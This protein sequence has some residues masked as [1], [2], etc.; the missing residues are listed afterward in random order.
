MLAM[1]DLSVVILALPQL[2]ADLNA[3]SVQAL[4][5]T[6]IYGFLIAGF[7]VTM[8]RLGDR[9]GHRNLLLIGAAAFGLLSIAAAYSTSAEMLIVIRALLGVAGGTI[10]PCVL[11]LLRHMFQ[12]PKQMGTAMGIWSAA[13]MAGVSLGPALGG[14]LLNS[15]WWGSIFLIATPIMLLLMATG[16]FLLPG[17]R[18]AADSGP[19]DLFSVVLSLAA[20]LPVI[21]GLKELARAG[22]SAQAIAAIAAGV[23]LGAIFVRRQRRL[24]DPLLDLGLFGIAA[25]GGGLVLYLLAGVIQGGNALLMTQHLQLVEG[26]SPLAT[27]LWLLIPSLMVIIGIQIAMAS[28]KRFRPASVMIAGALVA[29]AGMVVLTQIKPVGGLATMVIGISIVFIGVS[30]IPALV[31]Q[32]VM[33]SAPPERAGSAASLSTTSGELGTALGIATLGSLATLLYRGGVQVPAGVTPEAAAAA[34]DSMGSAAAAADRLPQP[35]AQELLTAARESFNAAYASVAGVC[36]VL[37]IGFAAL[38]YATLRRIPP[39]G[40]PPGGGPAPESADGPDAGDSPAPS[41]HT[42]DQHTTDQ[43]TTVQQATS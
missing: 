3:S 6:D 7:L 13:A 29:I 26:L 4:W 20:I 21:Y 9:I 28:A 11:G 12:D 36:I 37:F 34:G 31:N 22:W 40:A 5:I 19:L 30:P 17:H 15:F 18:A 33:M 32:L 23:A 42:T 41:Q 2:S 10:M 16:P 39:I 43:Q 25:I 14:V 38:A 27:A 8:G 24:A 35:I 1:L